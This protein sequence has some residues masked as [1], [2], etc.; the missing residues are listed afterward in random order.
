MWAGLRLRDSDL[1]NVWFAEENRN[2]QVKPQRGDSLSLY[3]KINLDVERNRSI[4]SFKT[5]QGRAV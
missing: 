1:E 4:Y 3:Y 2:M 5:W